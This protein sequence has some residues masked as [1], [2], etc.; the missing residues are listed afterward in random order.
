MF[1]IVE[2]LWVSGGGINDVCIGI[3]FFFFEIK[4]G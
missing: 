2:K 3:F 4:S 1:V